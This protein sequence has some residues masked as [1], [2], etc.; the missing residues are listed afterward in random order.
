MFNCLY[1]Q[2]NQPTSTSRRCFPVKDFPPDFIGTVTEELL[3]MVYS[4]W[5]CGLI[6]INIAAYCRSRRSVPPLSVTGIT[7]P[8]VLI[9]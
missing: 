9:L 2:L 3:A 7:G 8:L 5:S 4:R 1:K 6:D